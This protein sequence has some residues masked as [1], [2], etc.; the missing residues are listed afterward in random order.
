MV[1]GLLVA[2]AEE[3]EGLDRITPCGNCKTVEDG[4]TIEDMGNGKKVY[5][6]WYNVGPDTHAA[7]IVTETRAE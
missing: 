6:L 4:L 3:R 5:M 2:L 7:R 1:L